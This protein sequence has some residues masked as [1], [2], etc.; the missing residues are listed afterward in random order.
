[1]THTPF[2]SFFLSGALTA[3]ILSSAAPAAPA[4]RVRI[5]SIDQLQQPLPLPYNEKA[6]ADR[7]FA[8]AKGRAKARGKTLLVDLGGNWCGDCR[9]LAGIMNVPEVKAFLARHYEVVTIDVGRMDKNQQ[10]P[11]RYGIEKLAGVPALLVIDPRT[12]RLINKDRIFALSDARH[13][14]PQAL[15]DWLA[16]WV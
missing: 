1:M 16:Q 14:T 5:S 13:M 11:R 4:P 10:I 15:A 2:R 3:L 9:V 6:D 7:A 8:A 12:D